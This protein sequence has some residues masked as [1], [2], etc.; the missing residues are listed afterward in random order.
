MPSALEAHSD[1]V[2]RG[3]RE[4]ANHVGSPKNTNS[5]K[6]TRLKMCAPSR[7][8]GHLGRFG[9]ATQLDHQ[10]A[11]RA[12][13][14]PATSVSAHRPLLFSCKAPAKKRT[15]TCQLDS[16]T[17]NDPT[18]GHGVLLQHGELQREDLQQGLRASATRSLVLLKRAIRQVSQT[19][20]QEQQRAIPDHSSDDGPNHLALIMSFLLAAR[21][22]NWWRAR[23]LAQELECLGPFREM[24]GRGGSTEAALR[25][26]EGKA[27]EL[28]R[29]NFVAELR[30]EQELNKQSLLQEV[31]GHR[32]QRR[33]QLMAKLARLKPGSTTTLATLV[34]E[35]GRRVEDTAEKLLPAAALGR[36]LQGQAVQPTGSPALAETSP[37]GGG[38]QARLPH[39]R[40]SQVEHSA[41][42]RRESDRARR[43]LGPRTGR[44][45]LRHVEETW[46]A[47]CPAAPGGRPGAPATGRR[48]YPRK[49]I[50]G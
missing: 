49:G 43:G 37:P 18:W 16:R 48:G 3:C 41:Q 19:I 47:S 40:A 9:P 33:G 38:A 24:K 23:A 35:Q 34:D 39:P 10:I 14:W 2:K 1:L 42:R 26:L 27:M 29:K 50:P 32:A 46:P 36:G 30:R 6:S 8:E 28:A 12:L 22:Q 17:I 20:Q 15:G 44:H 5:R 31:P 25:Q 11:C 21:L 13:R 4:S 7:R 45:S